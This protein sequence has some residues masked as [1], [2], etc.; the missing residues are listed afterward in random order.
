[1]SFPVPSI[2]LGGGFQ[3][4]LSF[5]QDPFGKMIHFDEHMSNR[6]YLEKKG[7]ACGW[8]HVFFFKSTVPIGTR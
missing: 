7:I 3:T 1:M 2:H 4:C 6:L 5:H 8:K